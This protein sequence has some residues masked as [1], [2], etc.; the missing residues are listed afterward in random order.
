MGDSAL[1]RRA[2]HELVYCARTTDPEDT[3][4]VARVVAGELRAFETLY[5]A[6]ALRLQRF[7]ALMTPRGTLVDEALNDTMLVVWSRAATYNGTSKVSTWIFA[8]AHRTML[9]ALQRTDEPLADPAPEDQP[10]TKIGPEQQHALAQTRAAVWRALD[11]LSG[12]QRGV[13]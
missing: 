1:T 10:V 6:Y 9:K 2:E 4:L 3:A 8:I 7:L 11:A 5:R 13:L 12:Q